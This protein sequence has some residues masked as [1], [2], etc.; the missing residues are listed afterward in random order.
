MDLLLDL[1][2]AVSCHLSHEQRVAERAD[3]IIDAEVEADAEAV[4]DESEDQDAE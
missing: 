4:A 1:V 2:H 3:E